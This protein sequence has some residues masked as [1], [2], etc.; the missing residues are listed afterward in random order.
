MRI[1]LGNNH[2]RDM[3]GSETFTYAMAIELLRLGHSIDILTFNTG[4]V[5]DKLKEC[6]CNI[7]NKISPKSLYDICL[8]NHITCVEWVLVNLKSQKPNTIIQTCHGII[9]TLEKP[10]LNHDIRYVAISNE[11][12]ERLILNG[13][14]DATIIHNGI[15]LTRFNVRELPDKFTSIFSLSQSVK[16]NGILSTVSAELGVE[17]SF[18]NKNKNPIWDVENAI[19]KSQL[20]FGLGRSAYE[21]LSMGKTVFVA[22]Q[23]YGS[24]GQMD[25]IITLDNIDKFLLNNCSGR[26]SAIIPTVDNILKEINSHQI[27]QNNSREI[28]ERYFDIRRQVSKYLILS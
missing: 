28:A 1:L 24:R 10:H 22:D 19:E 14:N 25:G 15:D 17:F 12:N 20:V 23:R 11:V 16:F 9:P 27:C 6:G 18:N 3:G 13:I 26:Y 4:F 7:L 21:S 2:L 8:L 5:S